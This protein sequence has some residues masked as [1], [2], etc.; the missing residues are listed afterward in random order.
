MLGKENKRLSVQYPGADAGRQLL[1]A[2]EEVPNLVLLDGA[3][4]CHEVGDVT[5]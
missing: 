1:Q 2:L 4:I 5:S 3:E